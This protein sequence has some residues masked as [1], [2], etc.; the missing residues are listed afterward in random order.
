MNLKSV[1]ITGLCIMLASTGC[2]QDAEELRIGKS[3]VH[4]HA[5]ETVKVGCNISAQWSSDNDFIASVDSE[6][7]ITGHHVGRT[8][9]VAAAGGDKRECLVEVVPRY[10]TYIEPAYELL[11]RPASLLEAAETRELVRREEKKIIYKGEKPYIKEVSY[12]IVTSESYPDPIAIKA[13]IHIMGKEKYRE[14]IEEFL[15]ERHAI[16]TIEDAAAIF[17]CYGEEHEMLSLCT[18]YFNLTADSIMIEY[19]AV[20]K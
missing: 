11:G 14:E 16:N 4:L 8:S 13:E 15:A 19:G 1:L 18:A 5:E 3:E 17:S 9:V 2:R 7:N 10:D 12:T 20:A 6:G